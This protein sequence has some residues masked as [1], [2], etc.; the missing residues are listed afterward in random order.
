[1][2]VEPKKILIIRN[3]KLGDFVLAL[4]CFS[5]LK[6]AIPDCHLTALVP[7]YTQSIAKEFQD[8]DE[9]LID[10]GSTFNLAKK[11]K[12]QNFD[13]VIVLF[14]TTR[15]ALVTL[16][17]GIKIRLAPKT[18]IAQIFYKKP[19]LQK[20]SESIKPEYQYNLD[21]I[22]HFLNNNNIKIEGELKKPFW[23]I[24][25]ET[26]FDI[27]IHPGCGGSANNLSVAQ[28]AEIAN[29]LLQK[30]K[31]LSFAITAGA[32]ES[33][34]ATELLQAINTDN[35]QIITNLDL[36]GL[37]RHINNSNIFIGGSTGPLHLAGILNKKTVAFYPNLR[38]STA[39]RWQTLNEARNRL[40]FSP[41]NNIINDMSTIELQYVINQIWIKFYK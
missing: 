13:V 35:K 3:D 19:L 39:L 23:R 1:M 27:N 14:S 7:K 6:K 9:V 30:N 33:V 34:I 5:L 10:D 36:I 17:A 22:K 41:P 40:N 31:N 38:S 11:I 26:K 28:Y 12:Q 2:L 25:A 8:I 21:L 24:K 4:P 16:L 15:I 29:G 37:L 20:R 32:N 18:K